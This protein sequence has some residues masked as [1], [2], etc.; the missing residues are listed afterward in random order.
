[1]IVK[2]ASRASAA[3]VSGVFVTGGLGFVGCHLVRRLRTAKPDV[4]ITV[5]DGKLT[6][7]EN[8]LPLHTRMATL[9]EESVREEAEILVSDVRDVESL[10]AAVAEA[11]PDVIVHLAGVPLASVAAK[12]PAAVVT[13]NVQGTLNLLTAIDRGTC[14]TRFVFISSSYVYGNFIGD[15][16]LEDW[17]PAPIDLYGMSKHLG[18]VVVRSF[19]ERLG[20][21][22]VIVRPSAV[23][24]PYDTNQ[25]IVQ[26]CL[27]AALVG[28]PLRLHRGSSP[29]DFTYVEDLVDG[30]SRCVDA[31]D[32]GGLVFNLTAGEA[33][34]LEELVAAIGAFVPG[35]T[36]EYVDP[37]REYPKRGALSIERA[38]SVLGYEP[39][40]RLEDGIA[41]YL[42]AYEELLEDDGGYAA[43]RPPELEPVFH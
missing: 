32:A 28:R 5:Y 16:A 29:L 4:R 23:Y 38:R 12:D 1:M 15:R 17:Q 37:P 2:G 35:L 39:R 3:V 13:T 31:P 41:R 40:N 25:R 33:R 21:E 36:V 9:R 10:R 30:V 26:E 8:A 7:V 20:I 19:C 22:W 14:V 24:G 6:Y 43:L 27:E 34:T 11:Q 18:E 42:G